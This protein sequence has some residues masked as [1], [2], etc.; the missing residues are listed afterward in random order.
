M[1]LVAAMRPNSNGSSTGGVKKSTVWTRPTPA[2][3]STT[4]PSSKPV[5][6]ART[7]GS[8][9]GGRSR[10]RTARSADGSLQEQPPPA[11][12]EVSRTAALTPCAPPSH[13]RTAFATAGQVRRSA[14]DVDCSRR[15]PREEQRR[16]AAE[17][18]GDRHH[19]P[20]QRPEDRARQDGADERRPE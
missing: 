2:A 3:I 11:A 14:S 7:R 12:I 20:L 17:G 1:A 6:P 15:V 18:A 16:D 8:V 5:V 9:T 13:C 4:A 10:R 19:Q